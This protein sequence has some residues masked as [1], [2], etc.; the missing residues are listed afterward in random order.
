MDK[1]GPAEFFFL[2]FFVSVTTAGMN[3][4][5]HVSFYQNSDPSTQ[6]KRSNFVFKTFSILAALFFV[7]AVV[8]RF[9]MKQRF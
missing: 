5:H 1:L 9:G 8:F 4:L 2:C 6:A 7:L 3:R